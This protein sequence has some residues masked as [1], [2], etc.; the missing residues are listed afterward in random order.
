MTDIAE[1]LEKYEDQFTLDGELHPQPGVTREKAEAARELLFQSKR[2]RMKRAELVELFTSTDLSFSLGHVLNINMVP[3]LPEELEDLDAIAGSRTVNDFRPVVLRG[4][5]TTD[6]VEGAGVDEN[7][8]AAIIPEGTPYPHVVYSRNEESYYSSLRKRGLRADVTFEALINDDLGEIDELPTRFAEVV[9]KTHYAEVFQALE[10][11]TQGLSAA[12]LI[13]GQVVP[14]DARVSALALIAG[15]AEIEQREVN[16]NKIGEI[17]RYIVLVAPGKKKFLE[18]DIDQ[19]FNRVLYIQDGSKTLTPDPALRA[20]LPNYEIR[21]SPRLSG[22]EWRMF[23]APG[24]TE[25]PVL[26]RLSLRGYEQPEIRVRS[27]QGFYPGGGQVGIW[28][29]GFDADTA[30]YR[31]RLF[32]GAVLWDDNYVIKSPGTGTL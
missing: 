26:E 11:A 29:G 18:Y 13:D 31:L 5:I 3:Q 17:S 30:S 8:A 14:A 21:E 10:S 7:G 24:T 20:L 16:G 12:E 2:S 27:D 9:R 4:L 22:E 28:Q 23:P 1:L 6:G 32:T 15:A 25:R 19:T